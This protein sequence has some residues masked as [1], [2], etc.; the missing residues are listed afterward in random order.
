M[1]TGN[2]GECING[3]LL[4]TKPIYARTFIKNWERYRKPQVFLVYER[5][6]ILKR[7]DLIF[8]YVVK[9]GKGEEIGNFCAGRSWFYATLIESKWLRGH[10]RLENENTR[11]KE[12]ERVWS[13]Y[14]NGQLHTRDKRE[15]NRFW[16]DQDS[17]RSFV[18]MEDL[19][20][21]NKPVG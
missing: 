17:V 5:R 20:R 21:I 7:K 10:K 4:K 15:F 11:L 3:I 12:R 2:K 13:L 18:V 16:D 19:V 6:L 1:S 8:V 9:S 14:G